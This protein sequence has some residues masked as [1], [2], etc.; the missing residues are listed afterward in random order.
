LGSV[1]VIPNGFDPIR[2][3]VAAVDRAR[4]EGVSGRIFHE[5]TWGGY[6]LWAWPEQKVFIDGGSDFYGGELLRAHRHVLNIQPGWRDSLDTWRTDLVLVRTDGA[7]AD[8]LVHEPAW[9]PWYADSTA[10][11]FRRRPAP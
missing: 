8:E 3:P 7:M 9:R 1:Q 4:A 11:L 10:T 2:F 5:F 6:L